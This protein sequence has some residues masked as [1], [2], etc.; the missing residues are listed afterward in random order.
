L[1]KQTETGE[2][3]APARFCALSDDVL[4]EYKCFIPS[5]EADYSLQLDNIWQA[6]WYGMHFAASII[7][8]ISHARFPLSR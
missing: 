8:Q 4:T 3:N 1:K 5:A 6:V 2:R 7:S